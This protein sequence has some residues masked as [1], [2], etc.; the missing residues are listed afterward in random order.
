[1]KLCVFACIFKD[2]GTGLSIILFSSETKLP[3]NYVKIKYCSE[4]V[5]FLGTEVILHNYNCSDCF[6]YAKV[7]NCLK[8]GNCLLLP[9]L[10]DLVQIRKN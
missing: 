3:Y 4:V 5:F 8:A 2:K 7:V 6:D 1:M 10:H 9:I